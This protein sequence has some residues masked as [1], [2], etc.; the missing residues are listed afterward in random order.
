VNLSPDKRRVFAEAF[1]VLKPG[2]R[3]MISDIVLL[4]EIPDFIKNSFEAYIKK[5]LRR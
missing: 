1:R 2:G 4:K 5:E 3:L